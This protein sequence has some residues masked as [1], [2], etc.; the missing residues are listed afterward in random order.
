MSNSNELRRQIAPKTAYGRVM[1]T[2]MA[3]TKRVER[4]GI[5]ID[6]FLPLCSALRPALR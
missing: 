4:K 3:A 2:L 1:D 6:D 5:G